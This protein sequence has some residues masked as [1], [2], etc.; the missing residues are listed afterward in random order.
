[1]SRV[2]QDVQMFFA[3]VNGNIFLEGRYRGTEK[4]QSSRDL[5]IVPFKHANA[6]SLLNRER[7]NFCALLKI[8][9]HTINRNGYF[10]QLYSVEAPFAQ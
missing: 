7:F 10:P 6:L 9:S 8:P 1:M 3:C 2:T 4:P 5:N